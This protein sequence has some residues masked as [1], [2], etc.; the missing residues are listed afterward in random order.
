[1][2]ATVAASTPAPSVQPPTVGAA[3]PV[4]GPLSAP[5]ALPTAPDLDTRCGDPL[6]DGTGGI[7][8]AGVE[9]L[10]QGDVL[11]AGFVLTTP[12]VGSDPL[13]LAVQLH[14]ADGAVVHQLG[15]ELAGSQPVAAYVG[16]TPDAGL[17]RLDGTV[18]VEGAEVHAAFPASV[19]DDLG[20][21]WTWSAAAG[22]GAG[23]VTDTCPGTGTAG[24]V[25]PVVVG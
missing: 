5:T 12:P 1:V 14:S 22:D 24:P 8:L 21:H 25:A 17:Q 11:A 13:Y 16:M 19:L 3:S 23:D 6:D 20:A 4:P 10:R 2:P 9:L 7:D 18:H 15:I